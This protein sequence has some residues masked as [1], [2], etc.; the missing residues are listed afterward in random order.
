MKK[1][2]KGMTLVEVLATLV[3]LSLVTGVIWT[4]ISISTK[5]NVSE[6]SV[7]KLQQE[8]NYIVSELQRV[9]RNC[10]TYELIITTKEVKILNCKN[11]ENA[12]IPGYDGIVSNI[13]EYMPVRNPSEPDPI[14]T[15]K[16]NLNILDFK[17][18]DPVKRIRNI[19]IP[20]SL[21]RFKTN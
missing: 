10:Y 11:E 2:E 4:T 12:T 13:Y 8:A 1:N 7:L 3:L 19:S 6:T 5:F 21:S 16:D 18:I 14:D 15:T 17:V 9:H 20:I